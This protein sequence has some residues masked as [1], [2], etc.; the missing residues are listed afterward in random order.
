M[1]AEAEAEEAAEEA[2]ARLEEASSLRP[3]PP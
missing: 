3:P 2:Q 1:E